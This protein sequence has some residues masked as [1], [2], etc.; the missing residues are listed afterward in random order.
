M[1]PNGQLHIPQPKV[2]AIPKI[3]KGPLGHNMTP[4]QVSHTYNIVDNLVQ[5]PPAMS[6]LEVL[7]SFP[8]QKKALL[9][10]LGIVNPCDDHVFFFPI[11]TS[12][13]RPL[14]SSIAF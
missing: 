5:S 3:P 7:H 14:P 10:S 11:D 12:E 13:H 6:T 8:S 1:T 9:T 4:N 2:E